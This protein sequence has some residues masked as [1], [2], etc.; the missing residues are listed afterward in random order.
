[1]PAGAAGRSGDASDRGPERSGDVDAGSL[2]LGRDRPGPSAETGGAS[3]LVEERLAFGVCLFRSGGGTDSGNASARADSW[4]RI[5][6]FLR[7]PQ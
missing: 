4:R 6:A 7:L 5:L 1:M 2:C 3:Q